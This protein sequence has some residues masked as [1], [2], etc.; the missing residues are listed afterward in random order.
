MLKRE[1]AA[2]APPAPGAPG[3]P[4]GGRVVPHR[5]AH[6][7]APAGADGAPAGGEGST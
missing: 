2:A 7:A 6:D 1:G 3:V 5:A 4:G